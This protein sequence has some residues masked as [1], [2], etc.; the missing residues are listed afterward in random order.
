M[1]KKDSLQQQ[2]DNHRQKVDVDT[3]DLT[4]REIVR[5][6][7]EGE[8]KIAPAYQRKFRWSPHDESR[9]IES[10]FLG[11]PV[12]SIY[13][14]TNKKDS[15]WDLVDG[16]QRV[17]TLIHFIGDSPEALGLVN[18]EESLRLE[19]LDTLTSFEDKT[20]KDLPG[21]L[22]L[23][24]S[25]RSLRVT[26]LSDKSVY[27]VRFDMFER[28]NRGGIALSPQEVRSCIYRGDYAEF[29]REMAKY[30]RFDSL[31][32]LQKR[33]QSDGT[34]EE[35]V[36]KFFA[37]L[38]DRAN[39]K[40]QVK[41]FLNEYMDKTKEEYDET[42]DADLFKKSVNHLSDVLN[43]GAFKRPTDKVTPLNPLEACLVAIGE[44]IGSGA[45]M[46]TPPGDWINDAVLAKHSTKGTNAPTSLRARIDRARELFAAPAG[47]VPGE[48][49]AQPDPAAGQK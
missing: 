3:Y 7:T 33:K 24:F 47:V 4:I 15:S 28:L 26:A 22:Q 6:A 44:L 35:V 27:S 32:K 46:R 14:A 40:G 8:L 31:L 23:A 45:A 1:A 34:K 18:R 49:A 10:F 38:R 11:L 36:L 13:V 12:P 43:N 42:A 25:R 41:E 9:L 21:P 39:F 37:Y 20:F 2:L 30:E 17:S 29:L 16:L 19:K 48:T 5:M